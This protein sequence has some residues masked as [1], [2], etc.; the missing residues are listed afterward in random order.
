MRALVLLFA[1]AAL[2]ACSAPPPVESGPPTWHRDIKPMLGNRCVQC[3]HIGGIGPFELDS[4]AVARAE[5]GR[6]RIAVKDRRMPPWPASNS[7]AEYGPNGSMS[8]E[9]IASLE[10]WYD[11]AAP[12]GDPK[13]AA[14]QQLQTTGLSRVDRTVTMPEPFF[15][16]KSPDEY[17]C[18]VL[19]W[20]ETT[21]KFITGFNVRPGQPQ[22]VHHANL[23]YI[24]PDSVEKFQAKD[25]AEAGAG[26]ECY[27]FPSPAGEGGWIGTFVPGSLGADFPANTGLK[28]LPGSKLFMQVHYNITNGGPKPDATSIDLKLEDKVRREGS[29]QAWSDPKWL[30]SNGGMRIEAGDPDAVHRFSMDPT[31][32]LS[33][34]NHTFIDAQPIK[35]YMIT[36]HMHAWGKSAKMEIERADG[37][38]DC[39]LDIPKWQFHWQLPYSLLNPKILKPGDKLAVECHWD[40]SA[41]NQ[42]IVNGV[43]GPPKE[44]NWGPNTDDEMC[45]GGFFISQ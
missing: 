27:S 29:V 23:F 45:V 40:N 34:A 31:P 44:M 7:C 43:K 15:A 26:Y 8:D 16:Q 9:E 33:I 37:S 1:M 4:L 38:N 18:F 28:I 5:E 41:D 25:D 2:A 22:L 21:T 20:P 6:I 11:A 13:S 19:D 14:P 32:Y 30:G 36:A 12:E 42:P 39:L 17:R 10:A 3:H 35:I 24:H